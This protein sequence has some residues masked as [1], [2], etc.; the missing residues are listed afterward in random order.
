MTEYR[1]RL[2]NLVEKFDELLGTGGTFLALDEKESG[3]LRDLVG[4]ARRRLDNL[5]EG[6]LAVGLIGG[7][8]VGK[9]TIMNA[10]A[11]ETISSTSHRRP[12]TNE[13]LIYRHK[14]TS[15]PASFEMTKLPWIEY[16]HEAD[17]V[18]RIILCD[19][20]DYDSIVEQH[21]E[22]VTAFLETLDVLVWVLSPEKYADGQF[23]DFLERMPKDRRN[24]YFV[25]NKADIFFD[26]AEG[27]ERNGNDLAIAMSVLRD[28]LAV[29]GITDPVVYHV[30]AAEY[31]GNKKPSYW[32]QIELLRR[33]IFRERDIKE[34][35]GI[36]MLNID[37]ELGPV[38]GAL[39]REVAAVARLCDVLA[40]W[41]EAADDEIRTA[42]DNVERA[43]A[44]WADALVKESSEEQNPVDI[45][46]G[47]G[48]VIE[49]FAVRLHGRGG[50]DPRRSS[51]MRDKAVKD[52]RSVLKRHLALRRDR[53]YSELYR[54]L[55][56][57]GM[58]GE[59][60]RFLT[61]DECLSSFEDRV[62]GVLAAGGTARAD[63]L[64]PTFFRGVQRFVY[65]A[66]FLIFLLVL[67]GGD[68][69]SAFVD[70]PGVHQALTLG[71]AAVISL[72]SGRGLAAM[73]SLVLIGFAIG[74]RFY[75]K[76][77]NLIRSLEEKS[78][79]AMQQATGE[80]AA[81]A[82]KAQTRTT[83]EALA[84][85]ESKLSNLRNL[86]NDR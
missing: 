5:E 84:V 31:L 77:R 32:N 55:S 38:Y 69:V 13:V 50:I 81:E 61:F 76:Y 80:A 39:E 23:Y 71:V 7:T 44:L 18:R 52:L 29:A 8:G 4:G 42:A 48:R 22:T 24:Y 25:L 46:I 21:S 26:G 70:D 16:L 54:R 9:S 56:L 35:M 40:E 28:H 53:L 60:E 85:M 27:S 63:E 72:F 3:R 20:P 36:K 33:E 14:E 66:L 17:D 65:G 30:S 37:A 62:Y 12:H 1:D 11:A 79:R 83:G 6:V 78:S 64:M 47:P 15:L 86:L 59:I 45:L 34:L 67:P 75:G 74:W 73:A 10:L 49:L 41:T 19:L 58:P 51:K 82:L 2:L 57:A 43:A 68:N